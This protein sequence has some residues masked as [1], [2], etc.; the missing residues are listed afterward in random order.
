M[1]VV[2]NSCVPVPPLQSKAI[3]FLWLDRFWRDNCF[4]V[5]LTL[6]S[7]TLPGSLPH[8]LTIPVQCNLTSPLHA[9]LQAH[10]LQP[11]NLSHDFSS[12]Q[13]V[14]AVHPLQP[15]L[16]SH[17]CPHHILCVPPSHFTQECRHTTR[18]ACMIA[19]SQKLSHF[20]Q[21]RWHKH[22]FQP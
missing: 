7:V 20:L 3:E 1:L 13:P 10:S 5:Q 12:I 11:S 17:P 8:L 9:P 22:D 4:Q 14:C 21:D 16:C 15:Y 19:L 18:P 2:C 6:L